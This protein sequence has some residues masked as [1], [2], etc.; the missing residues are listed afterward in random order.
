MDV[1]KRRVLVGEDQRS[2]GEKT[3][4]EGLGEEDSQ[5]VAIGCLSAAKKAEDGEESTGRKEAQANNGNH[6]DVVVLEIAHA[7]TT[8]L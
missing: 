4:G 3:D 6:L 8:Y 5:V 2:D 1:G 7:V